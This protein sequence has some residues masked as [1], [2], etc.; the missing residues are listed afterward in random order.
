M[1]LRLLKDLDV[2]GRT[3][4]LRTGFDVPMNGVRVADDFRIR[5]AA[6]TVN[7]LVAQ[8]CKV[9]I[10]SHLGRPDGWD[11]TLSLLPA[12]ERLAELLGR[13]ILILKKEE[14]RLPD[15]AVPHIYFLRHDI[16]HADMPSLLRQMREKDLAIL[17]NLR[18]YPGEKG[19]DP[20]FSARLASYGEIF[21]NE[22]FS[23][24]HRYDASMT[25]VAGLLPAGAGLA[26]QAEVRAL[27]RLMKSPKNPFVVMMGGVKLADKAPA[28][29]NLARMANTVVLGGGLANLFLK[30]RGFQIG[31]SVWSE[32]DELSL[33]KRLLRD[34]ASKIKLPMDLVVSSSTAGEP[35]V[36]PVDKVKT[37]QMILDIGPKTILA[38]SRILKEGKTLLWSGALGYFEKP[39]FSHGTFALARLFAARSRGLAFG[40]AGGGQTVE[41]V[42]RLGLGEFIDH[43]S[44]GGGAMLEFL[45]GKKLPALEVLQK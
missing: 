43:L 21:V 18:F 39:S 17:E 35:E 30:V 33:A 9:V 34:H 22:A 44:T 38:Y 4:L 26:L 1:E 40:V 5:S 2:P 16:L 25:G 3:V 29:L 12:A 19:N 36:V 14:M 15:Y 6:A 32:K 24:C 10:L 28:L 45:A 7:Y 41:A 23:N 20:D 11:P 13:K 31:K 42:Q 27:S 37:S 8:R